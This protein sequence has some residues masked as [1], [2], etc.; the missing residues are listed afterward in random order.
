VRRPGLDLAVQTRN[1]E[2]GLP[3][4]VG[5]RTGGL[6]LLKLLL[7]LLVVDFW[8]GQ[9]VAEHEGVQAA[10]GRCGDCG[11]REGLRQRLLLWLL[12]HERLHGRLG[13]LG[14]PRPLLLLLLLLGGTG[15][16]ALLQGLHELY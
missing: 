5:F 7:P 3:S 14:R 6:L 9:V 10:G 4:S 15:S 8:R 13:L 2:E 1:L 12:Q 16:P 11:L